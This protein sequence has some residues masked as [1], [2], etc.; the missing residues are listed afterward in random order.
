[1]TPQTLRDQGQSRRDQRN[2]QQEIPADFPGRDTAGEHPRIKKRHTKITLQALREQGGN[3]MSLHSDIEDDRP[4]SELRRPFAEAA[5]PSHKSSSSS[6]GRSRGR[7]RLNFARGQQRQMLPNRKVHSVMR[8][9]KF[10]KGLGKA[11]H[12]LIRSMGYS[13]SGFSLKKGYSSCGLSQSNKITKGK[14]RGRPRGRPRNIPHPHVSV[15]NP[16]NRLSLDSI[17]VETDEQNFDA[18]ATFSDSELFESSQNCKQMRNLSPPTSSTN[19]TA[20]VRGVHIFPQGQSTSYK[21]SDNEDTGSHLQYSQVGSTPPPSPDVFL[22]NQETLQHNSKS[23]S[24]LIKPPRGILLHDKDRKRNTDSHNPPLNS[25]ETSMPQSTIAQS[26][27][28]KQKRSLANAT[29][30]D[31]IIHSF[32]KGPQ[33][34]TEV[35]VNQAQSDLLL[36]RP[37]CPSTKDA[38][39]SM[40]KYNIKVEN[41]DL[42]H[43]T[44]VQKRETENVTVSQGKIVK[45]PSEKQNKFTP[46]S[47]KSGSHRKTNSGS[48][49]PSQPDVVAHNRSS[50]ECQ[51][52]ASASDAEFAQPRKPSNRHH[53][54]RTNSQRSH[55]ANSLSSSASERRPAHDATKT[56]QE[57]TSSDQV[58]H[59]DL[60]VSEWL[61]SGPDAFTDPPSSHTPHQHARHNLEHGNSSHQR[62]HRKH[63]QMSLSAE[64]IIV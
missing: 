26:S 1:M 63:Y 19:Q 39:E 35:E 8:G 62:P 33:G 14:P 50:I 16:H 11:S 43:P 13:S 23:P 22:D 52:V 57:R 10:T 61:R 51:I 38:S 24:R 59:R 64:V 28:F 53:H 3:I 25:E 37:H 15:F 40:N 21:Q 2:S 17:I 46:S 44:H 47:S 12:G 48:H 27:R 54:R 5:S 41:K 31:R 60:R 20:S 42:L 18:S 30:K 34:V 32:V 9:R 7:P 55:T 49:Q 58:R 4:L 6:R 45:V 29:P 36:P 56:S